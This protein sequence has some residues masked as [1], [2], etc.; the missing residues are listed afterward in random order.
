MTI[1][2]AQRVTVVLET[3]IGDINIEVYGDKA[4]LSAASFLTAID[5]GMFEQ[6]RGAFYRVV[7]HA[8][9]TSQHKIDVV[10]GGSMDDSISL[11]FIKLET[12]RQTGI[13]HRE[14][15]V[16]IARGKHS[17]KSGN[18]TVF[19]ISIGDQP[20]LDY[21]GKRYDDGQG[22]AA[23]GQVTLGMDIVRRIQGMDT[24]QPSAEDPYFHQ[25]LLAPITVL[26]AYQK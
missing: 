17:T 10:Q 9:D 15:T 25:T 18:G 12:T 8:N 11:P 2:R 5:K 19:F 3:K 22:F 16:S 24:N 14:G 20:I 26:R 21:G 13:I 6:G 1:N 23:F 7:D 4:P